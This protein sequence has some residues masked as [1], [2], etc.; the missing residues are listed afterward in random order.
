MLKDLLDFCYYCFLLSSISIGS[1]IFHIN[2]FKVKCNDCLIY[3]I[4]LLKLALNILRIFTL[5]YRSSRK[6]VVD[7]SVSA[8][9]LTRIFAIATAVVILL[10][11]CLTRVVG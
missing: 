5:S 7:R 4:S 9:R 3:L 11:L 8:A 2:I 6:T 10:L 1:T